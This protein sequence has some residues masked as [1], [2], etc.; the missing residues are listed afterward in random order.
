M[1]RLAETFTLL[2]TLPT[3][4]STQ[5]DPRNSFVLQQIAASY[6]EFRQFGAMAAALDRAL[7]IAPHDL[8]LRV[9]RAFVDLEG[10]ADARPPQQTRSLPRIP[11]RLAIWQISGFT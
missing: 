3:L 2:R 10:S 6:Q 11:D 5:L 9:S 1:I 8:D 7:A 4:C